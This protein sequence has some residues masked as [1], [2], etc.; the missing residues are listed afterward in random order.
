MKYLV[1]GGAGFIGSHI[2][3]TLLERGHSVRIFDNLSSG[4]R[5][6]LKGLDVEVI[7]GDL[8][9]ADAVAKAVQGMEIIFH[10]AA[11]VS[12]PESMEKPQECFDVNV[13]GTS[14]LFE[15]ARDVYIES[16]RRL[17]SGKPETVKDITKDVHFKLESPDP[18]QKIRED[19]LLREAFESSKKQNARAPDRPKTLADKGTAPVLRR[20]LE[21]I[22]FTCPLR[23]PIGAAFKPDKDHYGIDIIGPEHSPIKA[24]L[25]GS[26]IQSDWSMENGHT[27]AIQHADNLVSV[28]KHNSTL[29][30]KL[31]AQVRAGEAI[32]IIGNTGTLT[33][34]PHLHFE[35]WYQGRCIN[36]Q[37][38]IR[39]N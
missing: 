4:K 34:G 28:Y 29:L 3:R 1:T 12:V 18:V 16:L 10:E 6:N 13:T 19:S 5:D 7:E 8:R 33:Q 2:S 15:A 37:E 9:D 24:V 39:F 35:L 38:Y 11:F 21:D 27:I 23:G 36:P 22:D 30:R 17:L 26:V 32:A 31:G 20:Q 14:I 25:P